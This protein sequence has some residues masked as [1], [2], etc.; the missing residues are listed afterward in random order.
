MAEYAPYDLYA[1]ENIGRAIDLFDN[2]SGM[3][4]I[5]QEAA[6]LPDRQGD[7]LGHSEFAVR[8]R[9]QPRGSA[10]MRAGGSGQHP[11]HRRP[12][13]RGL[14]SG[15]R[16]RARRWQPSLCGRAGTGVVML[17]IEKD[18]AVRNLE[19]V[20]GVGGVDMVQF[21][22]TDYAMSIDKPGQGG[23]PEVREAEAY[24]IKTAL[25][26]GIQPRAEIGSPDHAKRYLDMGVTHFSIGTDIG[27]LSSWW[28]QNG[29]ALRA[30]VDGA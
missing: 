2:F 12:A 14:A 6:D 18:E 21:G 5:E 27:I 19:N 22:P 15:H 20:I 1:L 24:V 3:M 9:P 28:A 8:R 26:M 7:R 29:E 16:V 13:R 25:G 4:K 10:R 11:V 17:M 23:A 30:A